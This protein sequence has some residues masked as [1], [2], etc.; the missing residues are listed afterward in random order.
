MFRTL[1]EAR[2][3]AATSAV[4]PHIDYERGGAIA[5][6]EAFF[7]KEGIAYFSVDEALM[8]FGSVE[9]T[10]FIHDGHLNEVRNRVVAEEARTFVLNHFDFP[11]R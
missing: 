1:D 7:E 2:W 3:I 5:R 10:Y 11:D 8:R 4:Q 9:E 6:L